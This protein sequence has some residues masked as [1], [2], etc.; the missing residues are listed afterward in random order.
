MFCHECVKNVEVTGAVYC[1]PK[2]RICY[3][4]LNLKK[5]PN[6]VQN[7]TLQRFIS[8]VKS[9]QVDKLPEFYSQ[10]CDSDC[11]LVLKFCFEQAI[12]NQETYI[13]F[14]DL[15]KQLITTK[16]VLPEGLITGINT[17]E[18]LAFFSNALTEI[19]GYKQANRQG[20]TVIHALCSNAQQTQWPFNFLRS[21]MLF[22]RNESLAHALGHKNH[23][24]MRPIDC[25]LAFNHNLAKLPDHEFSALLAL[26]EIQ[27]KTSQQSESGLLHAICQLLVKEKVNEQLDNAH[28]RVLLIASCFQTRVETVCTLLKI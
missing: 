28:Q 24:S 27:S 6:T 25:Y 22:E 13:F 12:K 4:K 1:F 2:P 20:N 19:E 14:Q 16:E 23:Q 18:R 9:Q 15:C 21:L 8:Y 10:L 7:Q 11:V 26:I 3:Y 17:L 5:I